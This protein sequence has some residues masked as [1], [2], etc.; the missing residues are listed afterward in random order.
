[1]SPHD[2]KKIALFGGSFNP[3]H[4]GHLAIL[5]YLLDQSFDEV[6]VIPVYQHPF[7]KPLAPFDHRFHMLTLLC[8]HLNKH[9]YQILTLEKDSQ[10]QP[11]YT[12]DTVKTLKSSYPTYHFTIV[13][14]SDQEVELQKWHHIEDLKKEA[15][16]FVLPRQGYHTSFLPNVSSSEIR[17]KLK[18]QE[19]ISAFTTAEIKKYLIEKRVYS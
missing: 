15:D 9:H 6:W 4:L 11:N 17:E 2:A 10:K 8:H 1:M 14:G 18:N 19:D 7:G 12:I 5:N 16:F 3:P 13:I